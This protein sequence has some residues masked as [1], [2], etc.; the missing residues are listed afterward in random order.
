ML[1]GTCHM[2]LS[3]VVMLDRPCFEVVWR[4]LANHSIRLFPLHFPSRASPCAI[5]FQLDSTH[6]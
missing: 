4:V 5:R 1:L 2:F 3:L 6:L